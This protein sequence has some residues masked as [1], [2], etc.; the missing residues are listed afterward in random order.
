VSRRLAVT[1]FVAVTLLALSACGGDDRRDA[2]AGAPARPTAGEDAPAE[3]TPEALS[4]GPTEAEWEQAQEIVAAYTVEERA[5]Q[6]IVASYPGPEPPVDLVRELHLGGV[7]VMGD[8]VRSPEQL[9]GALGELRAAT[10]GRPVPLIAAVDQEGG[11]VARVNGPA[12]EFP[13]LMTLGAARDPGLAADVAEASG[14]ELRSLGLGMVFAPVADVTSGP[15][16]PTI[17]SRSASSDP[18][19]VAEI[20]RAG[21][22]GYAE[23]GVVPVVKHF[24]GHGSVPADSHETLPVQE[25]TVEQLRERDLVPFGAAVEAGAPAVMVAHLDVRAVDPGV[26]SS[27]S[28]AVVGLLREDLGFEGLV[29]TDALDMGAVT[30]AY[31]P[32]DAAVRAVAAGADIALMPADTRAA[33]AALVAAVGAGDLP[34][35]RLAE[36]ATRVVALQLHQAASA[37]PADS[38]VLGSHA[39]LSYAASLAGLT[40]IAGPCEGRLVGDAV[41]VVGGSAADRSRFA[42]AAAAAGLDVGTGETVRLLAGTAPGTGDVV[43]ALDTPYGLGGSTA[44]TAAIALYGRTPEAFRALVDVLTGEARGG[45]TLPVEVGGVERAGC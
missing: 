11:L 1:V 14:R 13:S 40:V 33:H 36:A 9:A 18:Q 30:G 3:P 20:T 23:A 5:G 25:A 24:P 7:I 31:G 6:V 35:Q 32:G 2:T 22:D 29:V 28:S 37:P 19:L 26:P 42:D 10:A 34:A 39:D 17:G 45:G 15:D 4:W 41:Q 8:N 16:D 12:T 38:D 21:L 27:L 43:V 44:G